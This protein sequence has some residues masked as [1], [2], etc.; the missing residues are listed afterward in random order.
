MCTKRFSS[1]TSNI[2]AFLMPLLIFS[3]F[4]ALAESYE[5]QCELTFKSYVSP[6]IS[7]CVFSANQSGNLSF[8]LSGRNVDANRCFASSGLT[9]QEIDQLTG[10][11]RGENFAGEKGTLFIQDQNGMLSGRLISNSF[12]EEGLI[13]PQ[14]RKSFDGS[15][16]LILDIG[17]VVNLDVKRIANIELNGD[18]GSIKLSGPCTKFTNKTSA[19]S[20]SLSEAKKECA[21]LG[22]QTG[23]EK[24]GDCVMKLMP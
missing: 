13:L 23:T 3:A 24:F 1:H 8:K 11:I 4:D 12:P 10:M 22:F 5:K 20:H 9:K 16:E 7:G 14:T 2:F 19:S 18:F 15:V 6:S 17:L 21:S